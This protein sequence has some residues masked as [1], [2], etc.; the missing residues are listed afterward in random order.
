M[1]KQFYVYILTNKK[2]GILYTGV[3]RDLIRRVWEHRLGNIEGFTQ[4]YRI[5]KLV[6]YEITSDIQS[7]ILREKRIKRWSRDWKLRLIQS[8]N[9]Q[10]EDLYEQIIRA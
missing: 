10:W 1:E 4:K 5:K 2:D 9:P 6:Y 8:M 3:T 7:A